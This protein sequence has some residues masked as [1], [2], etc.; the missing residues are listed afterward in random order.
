MAARSA[1]RRHP[2]M[3]LAIASNSSIGRPGAL[4][5]WPIATRPPYLYCR[6][7]ADMDHIHAVGC[8]AEVEMHVDI[9]IEL[10]RHLK[11]PIDLAVRVGVGVGR[12]ADHAAAALER[13]D[14]ELVG[15][16][17]VEQPLLRKD[18]DFDDRWPIYIL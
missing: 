15:T 11:H 5:T 18:A 3:R 16:R 7:D 4:V 6:C 14:H 1:R 10:P 17:I 8:R 12:G 9:D 2:A 13:L